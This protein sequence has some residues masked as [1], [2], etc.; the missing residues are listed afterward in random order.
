[1]HQLRRLL[2]PDCELRAARQPRTAD[3]LQRALLA[4]LQFA[5]QR[6]GGS[7]GGGPERRPLRLG[8]VHVARAEYG[9][10]RQ[11]LTELEEETAACALDLLEPERAAITEHGERDS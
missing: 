6:L 1:M 8:D 2:G 4:Q 3:H 5:E 9:P 10:W 11:R 7:T